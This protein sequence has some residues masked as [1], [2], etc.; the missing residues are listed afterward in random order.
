[1]VGSAVGD[2]GG[3][4]AAVEAV[5]PAETAAAFRGFGGRRALRARGGVDVVELE[6]EGSSGDDA[7][8][9]RQKV[10]SDDAGDRKSA[11]LLLRL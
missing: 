10:S 2:G 5:A 3:R 1:M 7:G 4:Q 9:T 11:A 8:S 6:D